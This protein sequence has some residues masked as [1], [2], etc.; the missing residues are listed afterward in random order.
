MEIYGL[1]TAP[2]D[3]LQFTPDQLQFFWGVVVIFCFWVEGGGIFF[4]FL[5]WQF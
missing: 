3:Q 5:E 4:N 1:E 2:Q